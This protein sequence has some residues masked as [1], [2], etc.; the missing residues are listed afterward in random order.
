MKLYYS[1]K[2]GYINCYDTNDA[3]RAVAKGFTLVVEKP[4]VKKAPAKKKAA[5]K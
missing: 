5:K 2:G 4:P 1:E 3:A